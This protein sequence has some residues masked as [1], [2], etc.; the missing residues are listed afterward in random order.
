MM[1]NIAQAGFAQRLN[2]KPV[3]ACLVAAVRQRR[4]RQIQIKTCY[5]NDIGR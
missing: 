5:Q 4:T 2:L 1:T 3:V